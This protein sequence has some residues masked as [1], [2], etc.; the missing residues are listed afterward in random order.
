MT[1]GPFLT[2]FSLFSNSAPLLHE[3]DRNEFL[4]LLLS[5]YSVT[6]LDP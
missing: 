2:Q 4:G 1:T 6:T 5:V 3:D